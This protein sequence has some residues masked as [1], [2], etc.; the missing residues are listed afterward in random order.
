MQLSVLEYLLNQENIEYL[1][2]GG[3][4]RDKHFAV[5]PKD[6]DI[7]VRD[8]AAVRCILNS[9]WITYQ[10]FTNCPEY[11]DTNRFGS[12]LKIGDI[13]IIEIAEKAYSPLDQVQRFFDFNV[14]QFI[15]LNGYAMFVGENY[16]N[17]SRSSNEP[18]TLEREDKIRN[19]AEKFGWKLPERQEDIFG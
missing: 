9:N 5:I 16:G 7:F 14:N 3:Y 19:K 12:V 18:I 10:D 13:D 11:S 2:A 6:I 4:A 15:I 17:L 8:M 1:I